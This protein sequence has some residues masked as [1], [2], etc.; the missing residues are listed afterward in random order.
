[1]YII[2]NNKDFGS[3]LFICTLQRVHY[4]VSLYYFVFCISEQFL[5]FILCKS[6]ILCVSE[7]RRQTIKCVNDF[8][9]NVFKHFYSVTV[10]TKWSSRRSYSFKF[11][12]NYTSY[13][14]CVYIIF[15]SVHYPILETGRIIFIAM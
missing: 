11:E 12:G 13:D 10:H 3:I 1:M 5:N 9:Q 7:N 15:Y 14:L 2:G 8:Y 4:F 6:S